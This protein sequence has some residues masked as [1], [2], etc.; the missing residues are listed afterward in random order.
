MPIPRMP[1]EALTQELR[2]AVAFLARAAA[3]SITGQRLGMDGGRVLLRQTPGTEA[4]RLVIELER[5]DDGRGI[6]A[7]PTLPGVLAYGRSR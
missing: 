4:A 3:R 1:A 7:V 2:H 5:E 6:A